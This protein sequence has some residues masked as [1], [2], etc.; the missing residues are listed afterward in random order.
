[1]LP[2]GVPLERYVVR[3]SC[4]REF[5][6]RAAQ[7]LERGRGNLRLAGHSGGGGKHAVARGVIFA[8]TDRRA[9]Q[10]HRLFIIASDKLGVGGDAIVKRRTR[11]ARAQAQRAEGRLVCLLPITAKSQC[12]SVYALG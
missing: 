11:I 6:L 10:P 4:E 1:M 12:E 8:K 2:V 7:C 3:D 5:G 9:R